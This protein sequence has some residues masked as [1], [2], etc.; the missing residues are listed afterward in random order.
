MSERTTKIIVITMVVALFFLAREV[1]ENQRRLDRIVYLQESII[2]D[3][4][5]PDSM[6]DNHDHT[7]DSHDRPLEWYLDPNYKM[8]LPV[9]PDLSKKPPSTSRTPLWRQ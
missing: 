9:P 8:P 3:L 5:D 4:I 7:I 2:I 6:I 1:A